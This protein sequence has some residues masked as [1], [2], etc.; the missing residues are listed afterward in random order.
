MK[1]TYEKLTETIDAACKQHGYSWVVGFLESHI[2][3]NESDL[4]QNTLIA[5][6]T[7]NMEEKNATQI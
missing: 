4:Q 6:L 3:I 5:H 2:K 1:T 7:R